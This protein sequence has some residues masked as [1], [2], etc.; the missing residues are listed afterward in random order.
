MNFDSLFDGSDAHLLPTD[1]VERLRGSCSHGTLLELA[2]EAADEI[3][4]LRK[5]RDNYASTGHRL[6]LELECLIMD[7]K[8]LPVVSKWWDS[9]MHAIEDWHKQFPYNGPR[10]GD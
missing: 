4:R 6:A 3:E 9:A 5:E 1:I 7:T 2:Q 10:L 8:D